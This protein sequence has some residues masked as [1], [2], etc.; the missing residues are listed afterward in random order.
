M[1]RSGGVIRA[2]GWLAA[3]AAAALTSGLAGAHTKGT[4]GWCRAKQ[5]S[6]LGATGPRSVQVQ[7]G[8]AVL[9]FLQTAPRRALVHG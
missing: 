6:L 3:T 5:L 7:A 4:A 2:G 1:R 9:W 8:G